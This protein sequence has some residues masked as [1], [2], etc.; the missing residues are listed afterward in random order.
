MKK[1]ILDNESLLRDTVNRCSNPAQ[2]LEELGLNA[3]SGNYVT[4]KKYCKKFGIEIVLGKSKRVKR[5]PIL[6]M[7]TKDCEIA[8]HHIKRRIIKDNLI[9][10]E[11]AKCKNKGEWDNK[12]LSLQ[13]EH[14]NGVNNDNR[15]E[16]LEFLCPNCHSQTDSYAGKG[17]K[18]TGLV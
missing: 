13:L 1:S 11:C 2:V 12:P 14:K 4:L 18:Y 5:R 9:P 17:K 16:N 7:F 3:G 8:R 15:L 6:E 10:Y